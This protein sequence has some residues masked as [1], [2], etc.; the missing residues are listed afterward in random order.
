M[1]ALAPASPRGL[2][3]DA[4]DAALLD[5]TIFIDQHCWIRGKGGRKERFRLWDFQRE[6]VE[7]MDDEDRLLVLKARQLGISWCSDGFALWLCTANRGQTVLILSRRMDEALEEM[8]RIRFMHS[9]LPP[10]LRRRTASE[11]PGSSAPDTMKHLEF[12]DTDSR[13]I[14]L[15]TTENAGTSYTATLVIVQELAKIKN[16][17]ELMEGLTPTVGDDGRLFLISTAKGFG[18]VFAARWRA[19][20]HRWHTGQVVGDRGEP[21][22]FRPIFIPWHARPGRTAAW[23]E[24][25]RRTL[26][27]EGK[28]DRSVRQEYPATPREAFQG[29][30][31][32]VF[33]EEFDRNGPCV[34]DGTRP[35][36]GTFPVVV[37]YDPG[38]NHGFA[39]LIEVQGRSVFV[40]DEIYIQNGTVSEMGEELLARLRVE[41]DLD[42]AE[43]MVYVDPYAAGR[44]GQT[45]KNDWEV[46]AEMGLLVDSENDRYE[47]AQR[48][49]L[50]KVVLKAERVWVSLDCPRL[51]DA[52]EQAPWKTMR[53]QAGET[54]QGDTYDKDGKH[55]HP[56]DAFGT[57]LARIFP[58]IAVAA[59]DVEAAAAV[60]SY[61]YSASEYG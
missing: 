39:Y 30:A 27:S 28:S 9:N 49:E 44:N 56:L 46:L 55:E 4:V 58:P 43:C 20:Q 29:S 61:A 11:V 13:I 54:Y 14:S 15:P 22:D 36:G 52:L 5:P 7:A 48:V 17:T 1:T 6:T 3:R 57:A 50:I 35:R 21:G 19:A 2:S 16:A 45:K 33:A 32:A 60:G 59:A 34:L 47:P 53:S 18:G 31:D 38:V 10:E 40:F 12:P 51:I 24:G 37:G 25:M 23:Y 8:R 26:A 41:H 42:P